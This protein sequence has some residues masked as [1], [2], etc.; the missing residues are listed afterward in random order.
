MASR[1]AARDVGDPLRMMVAFT[2]ATFQSDGT[3][4]TQRFHFI[5]DKHPYQHI[6]SWYRFAQELKQN[7]VSAICIFDG[8][9][10]HKAKARE[11]SI[12][13]LCPGS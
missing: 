5:A 10:R 3:L 1:K 11:V 8:K 9:D 4:L 2:D 12:A 7:E 13:V 6:I